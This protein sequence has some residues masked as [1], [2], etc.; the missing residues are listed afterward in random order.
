MC[1]GY[2]VF[3]FPDRLVCR[4]V[5][6]RCNVNNT[7]GCQIAECDVEVFG[8]WGAPPTSEKQLL[9]AFHMQQTIN[10]SS[11]NASCWIIFIFQLLQETYRCTIS[12]TKS[13]LWFHPH[14]YLSRL[15]LFFLFTPF[16]QRELKQRP[17][18][19]NWFRRHSANDAAETRNHRVARS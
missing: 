17:P 6:M 15:M 7:S 8:H 9:L 11:A 1:C 3:H 18:P 12:P 2:T 4:G 10:P 16:W 19:T 13:Y 14:S 5:E